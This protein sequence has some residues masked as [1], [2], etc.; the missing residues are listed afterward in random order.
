MSIMLKLACYNWK[1]TILKCFSLFTILTVCPFISLSSLAC[2]PPTIYTLCLFIWMLLYSQLLHVCCY[3]IMIFSL[4]N[5]RI[6]CNS[7]WQYNTIHTNTNNLNWK[8]YEFITCLW[9][10][11]NEHLFLWQLKLQSFIFFTNLK[12]FPLA[13]TTIA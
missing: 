7:V 3:S 10:W 6:C 13:T 4:M 9:V 12:R 11:M 8:G 2:E 5:R 1:K